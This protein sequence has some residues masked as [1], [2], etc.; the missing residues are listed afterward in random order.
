[1]SPI[2]AEALRSGDPFAGGHPAVRVARFEVPY[3]ES[4]PNLPASD[5]YR[6]TERAQIRAR[7]PAL[8]GEER[9]GGIFISRQT[10]AW[11]APDIAA[12]HSIP[13]ILRLAGATTFGI[14]NGTLPEA[15][16]RQ[17]VEQFRRATLVVVPA[18]HL[19][20]PARRL[21]LRRITVIRNAVDLQRFSPQ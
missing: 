19:V 15:E 6:R 18:Q 5:E 17:L 10:F 4:A 20:E 21:G 11:D 12:A 13:C 14:L 16:V 9:P 8:I 7:L 2:T 1:L 3:F